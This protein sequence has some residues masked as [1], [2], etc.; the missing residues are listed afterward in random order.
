MYDLLS[1]DIWSITFPVGLQIQHA[2]DII[3]FAS[4]GLDAAVLTY[5]PVLFDAAALGEL[6]LEVLTG[7]LLDFVKIAVGTGNGYS[8]KDKNK[9]KTDKTKHW[10]GMSVKNQS[11][12]RVY[13][14]WSNP[15][16]S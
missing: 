4:F 6:C 8:L 2:E 12:R 9:A 3:T 10:I 16:P 1:L 14:K 11:R 13:L 15:H 7:T 5:L